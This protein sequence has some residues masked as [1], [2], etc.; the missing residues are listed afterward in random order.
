MYKILLNEGKDAV[1][2]EDHMKLKKVYEKTHTQDYKL[3][4]TEIY[5]KLFYYACKHNRKDTIKFLFQMYFDIFNDCEKVAIRQ[6]F[7]YGKMQIKK[8][9]IKEWY[10]K[11][12]LPI[13]K[14]N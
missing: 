8:K 5:L 14:V 7:Y 11:C 13:I 2:A 3:P 10:S 6:G 12:I 4:I 1:Y 9:Q